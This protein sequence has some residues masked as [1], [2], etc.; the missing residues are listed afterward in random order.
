LANT[1]R[2]GKDIVDLNSGY[3]KEETD[4]KEAFYSVLDVFKGRDYPNLLLS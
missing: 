1:L 4:E 3:Y 2:L